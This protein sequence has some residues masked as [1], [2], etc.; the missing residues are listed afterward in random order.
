MI[1]GE[2]K[3]REEQARM[4]RLKALVV[5]GGWEGHRP[6]EATEMFLPFLDETVTTSGW[7][8]RPTSTPTP[9]E[10]AGVD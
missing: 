8:S 10:M 6:V 7:R 2:C 1:I 4:T 5:R 3:R 9:G